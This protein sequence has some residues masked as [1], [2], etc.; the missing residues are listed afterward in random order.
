MSFSLEFEKI[1][2]ND[3]RIKKVNYFTF[4]TNF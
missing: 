4:T 1:N 2:K 3:V